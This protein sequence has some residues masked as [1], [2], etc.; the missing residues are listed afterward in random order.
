MWIRGESCRTFGR[1]TIFGG[2]DEGEVTRGVQSGAGTADRRGA[3]EAGAL[4]SGWDEDRSGCEQAQGGVGEE[5]GR[6]IRS[7]CE[8][9]IK[10]LLKQIEQVNEEEQEEYG[11]KDLE[12]MGGK[13]RDRC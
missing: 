13:G 1:S 4:F 5:D 3:C 8:Q 2:G 7:G 6:S 10:E 11:D 12:E 9:K